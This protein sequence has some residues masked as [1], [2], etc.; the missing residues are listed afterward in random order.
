MWVVA[1]LGVIQPAAEGTPMLKLLPVRSR[2]MSRGPHRRHKPGGQ[3][4]SRGCFTFSWQ[5]AFD[6]PEEDVP[7][8]RQTYET[9]S[10]LP[11]LG[12]QIRVVD[13]ATPGVRK[14]KGRPGDAH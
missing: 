11:A 1:I 7:P 13:T 14:L 3:L 4:P 5:C 10:A 8:P 2:A 12:S 9:H 6:D